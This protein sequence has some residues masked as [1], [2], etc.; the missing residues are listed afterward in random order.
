M[1]GLE[2]TV[3][4]ITP[5]FAEG[6]AHIVVGGGGR[7]AVVGRQNAIGV[8]VTSDFGQIIT[9]GEAGVVAE[10]A[11]RK[12]EGI[13]PAQTDFPARRAEVGA[14][15]F[16]GGCT[17]DIRQ[18]QG[19]GKHILRVADI[20]VCHKV[21]AAIEEGKVHTQVVGRDGLPGQVGRFGSAHGRIGRLVHA[22]ER[23]IEGVTGGNQVHIGVVVHLLVAEATDGE[24]QFRIV[25]HVLGRLVERL[26]RKTP[27]DGSGREPPPAAVRRETGRT[28][29]TDTGLQDVTIGPVVVRTGE[30]A[31]GLVAVDVLLDGGDGTLGHGEGRQVVR[32]Q[33]LLGNRG[34]HLAVFFPLAARDDFEIV[35]GETLLEGSEHIDTVA[36]VAGCYLFIIIA[37]GTG[38]ELLDDILFARILEGVVAELVQTVVLA[39][40]VGRRDEEGLHDIEIQGMGHREITARLVVVGH[41]RGQE[42]DTAGAERGVFAELVDILHDGSV[43]VERQDGG[44]DVGLQSRD[45]TFVILITAVGVVFAAIGDVGRIFEPIFD[46]GGELGTGGE[47]LIGIVR[48][49]EHTFLMEVTGGSIVGNLLGTAADGD[50]VLGL[51]TDATVQEAVPVEV[52]VIHIVAVVRHFGPWTGRVLGLVIATL[53]QFLQT[54]VL[55]GVVPDRTYTV[56][57]V[58]HKLVDQHDVVIT[59]RNEIGGRRVGLP[60]HTAAVG[61]RGIV[62]T[63]ALLGR[64]QD[65]ARGGLGAVDGAAGRILQDGHRLDVVGVDLAELHFH[66]IGQHERTAAVQGDRTTYVEVVTTFRRAGTEGNVHRR[67]GTLQRVGGRD[68]RTRI[69]FLAA[70]DGDGAGEAGF[71]LGTVTHD[72]HLVQRGCGSAHRKGVRLGLVAGKGNVLVLKTDVGYGQI[73]GE[74]GLIENETAVHIGESTVL[75]ARNEQADADERFAAFVD[76]HTLESLG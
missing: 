68:D 7:I 31:Q 8:V 60:T 61:D 69:D 64:N 14:V 62:A 16:R 34:G 27:G 4:L 73:E 39:V 24:T 57:G 75:G 54:P 58:V 9:E 76:D 25:H 15:L 59:R 40:V 47:I 11:A 63:L 50:I 33:A 67:V 41:L 38:G 18:G 70:D 13:V 30:E 23:V 74:M 10:F 35:L 32:R 52:A 53:Q 22:V 56:G 29:R 20:T 2:E 21:Q 46:L 1:V 51:G 55:L 49:L 72:H 26:F 43:R 37:R 6:H 65:N 66:S 5:D 3:H 28:V 12:F 48:H 45:G 36:A 71:L 19:V 44:R 42:T 17:I